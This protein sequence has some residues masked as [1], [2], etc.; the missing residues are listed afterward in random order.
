MKKFFRPLIL[1]VLILVLLQVSVNAYAKY[2]SPTEAFFVN[3]F[4][5]VL[6][7]ETER[8]M[9]A[10]GKQLEDKTT[11]QVV[12]VSVDSVGDESVEDYSINLAM[13]WG[14]GQKGKDN[15]ILMLFV[16][17][18]RMLRIEVGYGLEGAV[19]DIKTARIREDYIKPY[20]RHDDFDRG[21]LSGYAA[22]VHEV[23]K[24]Y[25]VEIDESIDGYM[26]PPEVYHESSDDSGIGVV[27]MLL[28]MFLVFDGVF[29]RFRITSAI[30]RMIIWSSMYNGR[31]GRGG[32]GGGSWG[33]GG[34]RGGS[35]GGGSHGSGSWSKGGSFGGGRSSGGGGRFGG[36]G[37]SGKV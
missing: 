27:F 16:R 3:D 24:E 33:G 4:A 22:L 28:V 2:P 11:A 1:T 9:Y 13:E 31:G 8:K 29:F 37:S 14:I 36:G 10:L 15:G 7:S 19:P 32:Y 12:F 5:D 30:I 21:F 25:G 26:V 20:T 17:D 35:W 34:Y 23:A 18:E 6:S